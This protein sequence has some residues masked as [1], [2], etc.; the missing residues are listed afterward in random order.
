MF[1]QLHAHSTGDDA[2]IPF[3]SNGHSSGLLR[4][5]SRESRYFDNEQIHEREIQIQDHGEIFKHAGI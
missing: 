1:R 3:K 4:P 2:D 5:R